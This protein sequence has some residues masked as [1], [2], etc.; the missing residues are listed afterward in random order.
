VKDMQ[1]ENKFDTMKK[2]LLASPVQQ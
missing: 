1:I 2:L